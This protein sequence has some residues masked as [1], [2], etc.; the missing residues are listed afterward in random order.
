M[1]SAAIL[2]G[3]L[4]TRL[5]SLVSDRPK[6]LAPVGG[7]LFLAYLLEQLA[8]AGIRRATLCTGYLGEQI[9]TAFGHHYGSLQLLYSRERQPLGT[10]GALRA[11]LPLLESDP[12]LVL[13]GDS[14]CEVDL[15][16][17]VAWHRSQRASGSLV[18]VPLE[19]VSRFGSVEFD[20]TG[21]ILSFG[22]KRRGGTGWINA[23]VYLLNRNVLEVVAPDGPVSLESEV[24]PV[25]VGNGLHAYAQGRRFVDIGTPASYAAAASLFASQGMP[26]REQQPPVLRDHPRVPARRYV[27]L[28]RDGTLNV[29]RVYL[30]D[31]VDVELLPGV[32]EGLKQL[33]DSGFGLVVITNQSAVGRGYFDQDELAAIHRRLCALLKEGGVELD[34]IYYCPHGPDENC[35]CRKPEPGLVYKA[36]ANLGF[37][38]RQAFVVGDKICDIDLGRRVGATTILVKTGYGAEAASRSDIRADHIVADLKEAAARIIGCCGPPHRPKG[39]EPP[40]ASGRRYLRHH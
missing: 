37:D 33:Q 7:R 9:E 35:S 19:D 10:A 23:G 17:F 14:Y 29:E 27:L 12:I 4:G 20:E 8:S 16:A 18:V 1:I 31:P 26:A 40:A 22:E 2:A 25:W 38:P 11:A 28:D 32:L 34:G 30:S 6:V 5:R 21:R 15:A 13:N 24:F 3:G 39:G 36:G